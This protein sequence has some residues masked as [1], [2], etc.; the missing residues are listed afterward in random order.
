MKPFLVV[1]AD[2]DLEMLLIGRGNDFKKWAKCEIDGGLFD[3]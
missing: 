3:F 2:T 1:A